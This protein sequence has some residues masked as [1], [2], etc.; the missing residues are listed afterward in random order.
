VQGIAPAGWHVPSYSEWTQL[1]N[2]VGSVSEYI[3][4]NNSTYIAK[5]LASKN[6]WQSSTNAY[7]VGNDLTANNKTLFSSVPA[8]YYNSL[9]FAGAGNNASFWSSKQYNSGN[10]YIRHLLYNNAKVD[11]ISYDKFGGFSVRCVCDLSPLDF[12]AWYY[13]EYGSYDHQIE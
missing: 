12:A 5:A 8:G 1:T 9:S 7:V 13:N 4:N 10:A 11:G 3:L 2:Y 6:Y